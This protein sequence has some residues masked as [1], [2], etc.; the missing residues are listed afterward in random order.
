MVEN[1]TVTEPLI[2]S[3]EILFIAR[4]PRVPALPP[5]DAQRRCPPVLPQFCGMFARSERNLPL[6]AAR[7]AESPG[8]QW[9]FVL[10][11]TKHLAKGR[12]Y[13]DA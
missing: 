7:E 1:Q 3:A 9:S 11:E 10:C 6:R 5:Q 8:R 2:H 12:E 13:V 4:Q